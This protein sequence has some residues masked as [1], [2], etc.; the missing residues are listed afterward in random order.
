[1]LR[2]GPYAGYTAITGPL[3]CLTDQ[4]NFSNDL[5]AKVRMQSR[6]TIDFTGEAPTLTQTHRCDLTTECDPQ[7]GEVRCQ[8][9]ASTDRMQFALMSV[10]PQVVVRMNCSASNPGTSASWAFADIDYLGTLMI[11]PIARSLAVDLR[12]A[13]FPAFEG[14]TS[15]NEGT[16]ILVFRYAPP[17]GFGPGRVPTGASRPMRAFL[18][19]QDGDGIFTVPRG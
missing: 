8:R 10:E 2:Q 14:Y 18:V 1:M 15:I 16:P 19:D 12:I 5:R 9:K 6:V 4:R 11:D 3:Y 13:L 7:T 17:T